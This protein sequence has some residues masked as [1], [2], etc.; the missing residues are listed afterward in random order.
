MKSILALASF[1]GGAAINPSNVTTGKK[2]NTA[3]SWFKKKGDSGLQSVNV[4][5]NSDIQI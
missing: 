3:K 5:Y 4:D 2:Q 1:S